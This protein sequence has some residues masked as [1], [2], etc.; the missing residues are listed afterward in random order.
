MNVKF[1]VRAFLCLYLGLSTSHLKAQELKVGDTLPLELW[2]LPLNVINHP[3][4]KETITLNEYNGKLIILDFWATWCTPCVAMLPRMDSLQSEFAEQLQIIPLTYQS[5]K[6]VTEFMDKY[7]RRTGREIA[8]PKVVEEK[9]LHRAFQHTAIPHYAWIG[10]D[11][12]VKAITGHEEISAE[13]IRAI[14]SNDNTVLPTK[15]DPKRIP[16]DA[17]KPFLVNGNGGDGRNLVYQSAL[18]GYTEGLRAGFSIRVDST[19]NGKISLFNVPLH[20]YYLK[21]YGADSVWFGP[22]RIEINMSKPQRITHADSCGPYK[23]WK[24]K[25][26]HC[27]QLV[28]PETSRLGLFNALRQ[29]L[30]RI[31]PDI[32]AA[33][34]PRRKLCWVL[35]KLEG[36][37]IP[38][39]EKKSPFTARI[40]PRGYILQNGRLSSLVW[41]MNMFILPR[42]P[43]PLIDETGITDNVSLQINAQLNNMAAVSKEL[44]KYGLQITREYREINM[45]IF[46]DK[47]PEKL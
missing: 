38:L 8:L 34:E 37:E 47:H 40:I 11:G 2:S 18:T 9:A 20:W 31:F 39:P 35:S 16:Y 42:S 4:G 10:T 27:Y 45:L 14:L 30:T 6:E 23:V 32:E 12:R 13:K 5:R 15:A 44:E 21:A 36:A 43:L 46:R 17:A 19:G 24:E 25:Y 33:I 22:N 1:Y 41:D 26:T 29:D 3:S 7:T 28:L